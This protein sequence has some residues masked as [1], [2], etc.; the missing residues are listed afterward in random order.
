MFWKE[1]FQTFAAGNRK[2]VFLTKRSVFIIIFR[3]IQVVASPLVLIVLRFEII[4]SLLLEDLGSGY[5]ELKIALKTL[6]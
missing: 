1:L 4:R 3:R 6:S 5:G 2:I